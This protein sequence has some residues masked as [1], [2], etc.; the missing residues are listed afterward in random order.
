LAADAFNLSPD[1]AQGWLETLAPSSDAQETWW[2]PSLL[3]HRLYLTETSAPDNLTSSIRAVL[4]KDRRVMVVRDHDGSG[5]VIPGGRREAGEDQMA[6][7]RRELAE[8][9]GWAISSA[10]PIGFI[11]FRHLTARPPDYA[12]PYPLFF[13]ALYVAEASDFDRRRIRRDN[14]E[15][16]S[17]MM[18]LPRAR[19]T[20][21]D[22]QRTLLNA[23]IGAR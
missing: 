21:R 17:A 7:L 14:W 23:A 22:D 11:H 16:N 1:D 13:Q 6:T 12:Y 2:G 19:A 18:T 15:T 9:T 8:E 10:R 20:I 4:F 5:H 3:T